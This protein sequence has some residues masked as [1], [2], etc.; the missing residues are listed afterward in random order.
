MVGLS[1]GTRPDS[2][3]DQ[4]IELLTE[5]AR[6]RYICVELGLQSADDAILTGINRGH[7]LAEY[8]QAVERLS[9]RGIDLCTHLIYG[10][11]GETRAGF[12]KSARMIAGL[13]MNSIKLHQ[14]HAVEGTR[15]AELYRNGSYRPITLDEYLGG[16]CDFLEELPARVS[17]QRLYGSAPLAI[18]VAPNWNLKNNQMWFAVVNELKRRGSWQGCRA[19]GTVRAVNGEW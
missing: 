14:L 19:D 10:F 6:D 11:P 15:L 8:L 4:T 17:I 2:I 5:L 13:P 1:I 7:T 3:T 16:V 9:G 18:R 12:L